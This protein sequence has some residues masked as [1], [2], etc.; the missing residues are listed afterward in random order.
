MTIATLDIFSTSLTESEARE[1]IKRIKGHW[2]AFW[3]ELKDFHDRQGWLALGYDTFEDCVDKEL[4]ISKVHAY[5][6]I[7]AATMREELASNPGVTLELAS[8]RQL[9]ELKPL[10][11]EQR[12]EVARRIDFA[13]TP[14]R[15]VREIVRE[16]M[17]AGWQAGVEIATEQVRQNQAMEVTVYSHRSVEYYTP[18]EILDAAREVLGGFDLDPASCAEAQAN[19][20]AAHFYTAQDDGLT[21]PW[22]GRV[23]LNPPYS[24]TA[25]R[26][27]QDI[28]AQHLIR[29]YE[30]GNVKAAILLVK[31]ALGYKWFED[32]FARWP[33]CFV[34]NRLSFIQEDGDDD[35][36]SKQGTALF[37]FGPDF[38]GFARVFRQFGRVIPPEDVLDAALFGQQG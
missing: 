5:R 14:V 32:L 13:T 24:K 30:R 36:Q 12:L 33:V 21:K 38:C 22:F 25:G 7:A 9:R 3:F 11:P 15:E 28:W 35:G 19:V 2:Q 10:E 1:Q 31:A 17:E 29:E 4:G 26:S 27:N 37:Y 18:I 20:K 8:E 16:A 6:L 34:R 23:W